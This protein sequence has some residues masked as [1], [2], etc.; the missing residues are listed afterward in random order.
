MNFAVRSRDPRSKGAQAQVKLSGRLLRLFTGGE[1]RIG[2]VVEVEW[3]NVARSHEIRERR[4]QPKLIRVAKREASGHENVCE[5]RQDL[6]MLV[7]V[8]SHIGSMFMK[9]HLN[10]WIYYIYT[11]PYING[12]CEWSLALRLLL[13]LIEVESENVIIYDLTFCVDLLYVTDVT[14]RECLW[15]W[16]SQLLCMC[17]AYNCEIIGNLLGNCVPGF[18]NYRNTI[19]T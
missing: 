8:T 5:W 14:E 10:E 16:H 4:Q 1:S 7:I 9:T 2:I 19:S 15:S 13:I 11:N 6:A 18:L 17:F 12:E 3:V